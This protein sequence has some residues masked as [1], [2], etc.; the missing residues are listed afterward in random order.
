MSRN[1][2]GDESFNPDEWIKWRVIF[3]GWTIIG[4][5]FVGRNIVSAVSRGQML[6]WHRAILFEIIYWQLW[7]VWTPLIFRVARRF[8]I[9]GKNKLQAIAPLVLFGV[10]IALLHISIEYVVNLALAWGV[11]HVPAE[12]INQV[13]AG[14]KRT[15]LIESF[16][17]FLTYSA[18]VALYYALD[19]YRRF[20]E[21]DVKASQLEAQ[22][23]QAQLHALKMQ[24]HPHFLFNTL[25]T[26]SVLMQENVPAANR[27]LVRL[28]DLL[29]L[30]LESGSA[31]EVSLKQELEFLQRY[32]DIEQIRFQDRLTVS[33]DI[34]PATL[35][36]RVPNLILQPL[37]EN[38]IRHGIAPRAEA[39]RIEISA[40]RVDTIMRL[41]VRDNGPGL[42]HDEQN[43]LTKGVGLSNTEA[44]LCQLYGAAHRF[45]LSDATD[46][47][48]VVTIE[49]PFRSESEARKVS[50]G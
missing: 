1:P 45:D 44:R 42:R 32:L 7:A 12:E 24:L 39:G 33:T 10:V 27:M 26:I 22:L 20:R 36:A 2:P 21:R 40:R 38:A 25:N 18:I 5:F 11:I 41:Q 28:S 50:K 47:G 35:D 49:L 16:T 6:A 14:I 43:P 34:D 13:I 30:T 37:V 48:L 31:Q 3:L 8:R 19:Y 23:S 46:G 4:L 9:E 29:R 17:G 15:I